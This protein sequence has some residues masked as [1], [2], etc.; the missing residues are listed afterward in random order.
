MKRIFLVGL[1]L[2]LLVMLGACA[3]NTA[4][5]PVPTSSPAIQKE[6]TVITS[7]IATA[8]PTIPPLPARRITEQREVIDDLHPEGHRPTKAPAPTTTA[9]PSGMSLLF[10]PPAASKSPDGIWFWENV[11]V[12]VRVGKDFETIHFV[13]ADGAKEWSVQTTAEEVEKLGKWGQAFYQPIFWSPTEP[14]VFLVGN[15]CCGGGL[16]SAYT[17]TSLVRL[18]LDTGAVSMLVPWRSLHAFSFSPTGKYL[19][20]ATNGEHSIHSMRLKDGHDIE[21]KLP[22]RY[23]DFGAGFWSPDGK[24]FI[25]TVCE[26]DDPRDEIC[27]KHPVLLFDPESE[28]YQV[29]IPDSQYWFATWADATRLQLTSDDGE[30]IFN[31]ETGAFEP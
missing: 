10:Y 18:N 6:P 7:V 3:A 28:E 11:P 4:D 31:V 2:V 8:R 29:I 20:R 24:R 12:D 21:I 1:A 27:Q 25:V 9:T 19:N 15:V 14:Y 22:E 30:K 26:V 17:D 16:G 23:Q 5:V 13:R